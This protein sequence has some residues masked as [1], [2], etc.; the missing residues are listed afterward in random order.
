MSF[1]GGLVQPILSD[2]AKEALLSSGKS[3]QNRSSSSGC[4]KPLLITF[5]VF[6]V[7]IMIIVLTK[8]DPI[9]KIT[10]WE[11]VKNW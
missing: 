5:A 9:P 7:F 11:K 6:F 3:P 4:L 2:I 1:L 8:S 10:D